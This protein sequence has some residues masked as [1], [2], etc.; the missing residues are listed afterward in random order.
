MLLG[1]AARA[2]KY[3][4]LTPRFKAAYTWLEQQKDLENLECGR[5]DILGD[6]VFA[7]V[8]SY[9]SVSADSKEF[10]AHKKYFDIQ[11]IISGTEK[12]YI[13]PTSELE[14]LEEND[15]DDYLVL[16]TPETSDC[17]TMHP[18]EMLIVGPEEAHKPGCEATC[19]ETMKKIVF[20][21]LVD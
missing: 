5:H 2:W 17:I 18:G 15:V 3:D 16:K 13:A 10:E 7:N 1:K 14:V 6:E 20:K 9:T 11:F 8:Q 12:I 21:V 19:P 4:Y